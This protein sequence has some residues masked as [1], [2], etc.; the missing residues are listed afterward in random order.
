MLLKTKPQFSLLLTEATVCDLLIRDFSHE[1]CS[2]S[3][4][5][6]ERRARAYKLAATDRRQGDDTDV[7]ESDVTGLENR[8]PSRDYTTAIIEYEEIMEDY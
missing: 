3:E 2:D 1:W 7:D 5:V 8:A 4:V 6:S